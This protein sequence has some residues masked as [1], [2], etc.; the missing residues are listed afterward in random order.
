MRIES[1]EA[2][3]KGFLG[4]WPMAADGPGHFG[5]RSPESRVQRSHHETKRIGQMLLALRRRERH[6]ASMAFLRRTMNESRA[7]DEI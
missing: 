7:H 3:C 6:N 2:K 1:D 4:D 5:T